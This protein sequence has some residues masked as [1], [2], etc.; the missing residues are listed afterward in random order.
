MVSPLGPI[1]ANWFIG[2]TE[3]KIFDQHLSFYPSFYVRYVFHLQFLNR[4][5]IG[6]KLLN[7]QHPNLR[8]TC[9]KASGT[10]S[11]FFDVELMICDGEFNISVYRKPT[12]T[13]V[14]LHFNSIAPLSWKRDLITCLLH[15][16]YLYSSNDLSLKTEFNFIIFI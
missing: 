2:M 4:C 9:E 12:F 3:K 13:G 16:V 1:S 14:L 10:S 7:S 15:C 11:P 8:F 5:S 6:L